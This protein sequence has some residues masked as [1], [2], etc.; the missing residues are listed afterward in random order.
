ML[1]E[2]SVD[3]RGKCHAHPPERRQMRPCCYSLDRH[4]TYRLAALLD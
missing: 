4:P 1:A 2:G 3:V